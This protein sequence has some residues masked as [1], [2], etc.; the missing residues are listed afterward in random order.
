MILSLYVCMFCGCIPFLSF[1]KLIIQVF[2]LSLFF[3]SCAKQFI[4]GPRIVPR[5][6]NSE[7]TESR[8]LDPQGILSLLVPWVSQVFISF[9][10]LIEETVF[11]S[12][13]HVQNL[14]FCLQISV[15]LFDIFF[16]CCVLNCL[17]M[18]HSLQPHG[19]QPAR[20]LCPRGFSRQ[21]YWSGLP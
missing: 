18:S 9:I 1:P 4:M 10:S 21:E 13:N 3:S 6:L 2:F 12:I 11:G 14:L 19:L 20:F 8:S 15:L 17:V 5:V 7:S 16:L